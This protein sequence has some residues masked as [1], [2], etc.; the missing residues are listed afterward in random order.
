MDPARIKS[1]PLFADLSRK[2]RKQV[3]QWADEIE[4][5]EGAHLVTQGEFAYEFFVIREGAAEVTQDDR[6]VRYLGPGDFFGEIAL[7]DEDRRTAS[8][9]ATSPMRLVA[10]FGRD[11]R[12]MTG[13][14]PE[15]VDKV[16]RAIEE[17]LGSAE[18]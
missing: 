2:E 12:A 8:V 17:R 18:A 16:R 7:L 3:A 9:V 4:V 13:T 1:I 14:V 11:F 10:M 5:D 6:H 15:V